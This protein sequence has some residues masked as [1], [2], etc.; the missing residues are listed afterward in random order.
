MTSPLRAARASLVLSRA[1]FA[2]HSAAGNWGMTRG[3]LNYAI[4][5]LARARRVE[6]VP[7]HARG[8]IWVRPRR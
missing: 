8:V 2:L 4:D 3:E 7:D 6:L 5:D 1:P